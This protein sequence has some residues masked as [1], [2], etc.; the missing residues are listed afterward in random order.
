MRRAKELAEG[1]AALDGISVDPSHVHSN[2]VRFAVTS[3][4]AADFAER[5][6]CRRCPHDPGRGRGGVRAVL[7]RDIS[8]E[9]V[10]AALAAMASALPQTVASA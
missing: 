6:H 7:H 1:L 3:G 8:D 9:D 2:I 10:K 5:C 4:P